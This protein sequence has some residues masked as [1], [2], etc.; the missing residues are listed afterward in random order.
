MTVKYLVHY[1]AMQCVGV[2]S[3]ADS[4]LLYGDKVIVKTPRGQEVG[5][6]LGEAA[7][8][9]RAKHVPHGIE[10][11][12]LRPMTETD[13]EKNQKLLE[14]ER[15]ELQLCK[16][17]IQSMGISMDLVRVEHLFGG[18]RMIIYYTAKGRVD[19]REL[20]KTVA[21]EFH[22][23]IEMR[24]INMRDKIKLLACVGDCGRKAC[25]GCYLH[26][27]PL[28]TIKMVKQQKVAIDPAKISGLCGHLKCCLRYE[29]E[30]YTGKK[31]KT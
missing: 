1:G 22:T 27:P 7:R 29:Q 5:T 18:E 28:V 23:R 13:A 26:A 14:D 19:F 9:V 12:I 20:V 11:R 6:V 10:D 4:L 2:F 31:K 21:A 15:E 25:C 24:Q 17:I 16:Q 3:Y 30:Y 8:E